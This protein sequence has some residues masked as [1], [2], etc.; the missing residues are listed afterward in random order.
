MEAHP[1]LQEFLNSYS[2]SIQ[3]LF[4]HLRSFIINQD[5]NA[6]ELI[7]DNYNAL[8][9]AY[10]RSEKLKDAYC[11][12]AL[13]SKHI[14]FG[15]NRGAE[16]AQDIITLNGSGKLIRHIK[17]TKQDDMNQVALSQLM[18]EACALSLSR[19]PELESILKSPS[20]IVMSI[21]KNRIRPKT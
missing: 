16:L 17:M 8:A 4:W 6:N 12:L 19:N 11:H 2:P 13:Y 18:N 1:Q 20:S 14:N 10:A 7:W 9:I 5:E 21:A 15:F 3:E